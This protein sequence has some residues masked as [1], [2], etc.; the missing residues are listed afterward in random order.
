[1]TIPQWF[2]LLGWLIYISGIVLT[3][4]WLEKNNVQ[5]PELWIADDS[6]LARWIASFLWYLFWPSII[7][8]RL[9]ENLEWRT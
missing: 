1:M 4:R 8:Y 3:R 9:R 5:F 7:W 6:Y 2:D